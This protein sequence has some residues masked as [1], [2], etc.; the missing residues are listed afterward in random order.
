MNDSIAVVATSTF[1]TDRRPARTDP[2]VDESEAME[3]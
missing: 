3:D 1:G 2:G